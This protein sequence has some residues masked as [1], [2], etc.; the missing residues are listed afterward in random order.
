MALLSLFQRLDAIFQF[1]QKMGA[2]LLGE[3]GVI[4]L[5][6]TDFAQMTG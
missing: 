6:A 1:V 3:T 2:V 5:T 4:S